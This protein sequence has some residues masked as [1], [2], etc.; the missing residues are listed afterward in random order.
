MQVF[1]VVFFFFSCSV[2]SCCTQL[3]LPVGSARISCCLSPKFRRCESSVPSLPHPAL[4]IS[5]LWNLHQTRK[6]RK[7]GMEVVMEVGLFLTLHI[8]CCHIFISITIIPYKSW[9]Y[10]E[11]ASSQNPKWETWSGFSA[12]SILIWISILEHLLPFVGNHPEVS[13]NMLGHCLGFLSLQPPPFILGKDEKMT[14]LPLCSPSHWFKDHFLKFK[15][16]VWNSGRTFTLQ[17]QALA[18]QKISDF[19]LRYLVIV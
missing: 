5:H 8:P 2:C 16:S 17:S 10:C 7:S 13:G 15:G 18:N 19:K 1:F 9:K 4:R 6:S 12:L 14:L 11:A 3:C